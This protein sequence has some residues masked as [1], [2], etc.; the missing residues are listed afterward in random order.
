MELSSTSVD[1]KYNLRKKLYENRDVF[2]EVNEKSVALEIPI[3]EKQ[4]LDAIREHVSH[5]REIL[6]KE[7][8]MHKHLTDEK[9]KL[10]TFENSCKSICLECQQKVSMIANSFDEH[11]FQTQ[12]LQ[13]HIDGVIYAIGQIYELINNNVTEKNKTLKELVDKN[14]TKIKYLS[15][16]Y[17]IIRNTNIGHLCPV[18]LTNE[19]NTFCE[20][21]GHSFCNKCMKSTYCY[22]CRLKIN[23]LHPLFFP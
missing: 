3:E 18:C 23:K 9:I 14:K 7:L 5:G 11:G 15:D 4:Q 22:I 17:N 12:D 1:E 21:C 13:D 19:V 2:H 8:D 16:T 6:L 20:P 10:E